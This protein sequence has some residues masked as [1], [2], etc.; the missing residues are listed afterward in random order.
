MQDPE[1]QGTGC[2]AGR[3]IRPSKQ[4]APCSKRQL[5]RVGGE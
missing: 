4:P 3:P 2:N 1:K 5:E